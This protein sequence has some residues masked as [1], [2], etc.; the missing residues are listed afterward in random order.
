MKILIL[1]P[2]QITRWNPGHQQFRNAIGDQHEVKYYGKGYESFKKLKEITHVPS[3]IDYYI[4]N[5]FYPEVVMTYGLNYTLPFFGLKEVKIPKVHFVCDF[6]PAIPGWPGTIGTYTK[7]LDD[8]EY[9]VYFALT[10]R[11]MDWFKIHRPFSLIYFL[12]FGVDE[13]VFRPI[14]LAKSW[15]VYI[16]WSKHDAIYPTRQPIEDALKVYFPH[17]KV[18]I[19]RAFNENF[20]IT[21]NKSRIVLNSTNAFRTTNMKHFEVTACKQL[22]MTEKTDEFEELGYK[23]MVHYVRF[24]GSKD[25]V[26][27][28]KTLLEMP[29]MRKEIAQAGYDL[30]MERHTNWHRVKEMTRRLN[31]AI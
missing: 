19:K 12:P 9:N 13:K 4:K 28:I 25:M 16:G 11:V 17:K 14:S 30:T 5:D 2:N 21:M 23:D 29:K 31:E 3:I 6:T 8:H 15:D 18:L 1:G 7:M 22:L 10:R 24:D 20:V 26:S 27:K